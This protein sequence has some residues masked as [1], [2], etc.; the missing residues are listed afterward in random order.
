MTD[1]SVHFSV[2]N[3]KL[4]WIE[5]MAVYGPRIAFLEGKDDVKSFRGW[6]QSL[7]L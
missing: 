1:F 3:T 7:L 4:Q 5:K 2:W 6:F